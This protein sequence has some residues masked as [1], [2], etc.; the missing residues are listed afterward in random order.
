MH[1]RLH[2][3]FNTIVLTNQLN[4]IRVIAIWIPSRSTAPIIIF[5]ILRGFGPNAIVSSMLAI[6]VQIS[7][8]WKIWVR[9]C[10]VCDRHSGCVNRKLDLWKANLLNN[11]G[12]VYSQILAGSKMLF[13]TLF[14][15]TARSAL[16]RTKWKNDM[17]M[18]GV[19]AEIDIYR[20]IQTESHLVLW[21]S[22]SSRS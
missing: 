17:V 11:S 13:C 21:Y 18:L 12:C 4:V 15:I 6:T 8:D 16:C 19:K 9:I 20:E 22:S 2:C 5:A 3:R 14:F 10:I 1:S 7:N